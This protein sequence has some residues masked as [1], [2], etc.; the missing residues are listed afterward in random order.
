MKHSLRLIASSALGVA[1]A[2][3]FPQAASA[4]GYLKIGDI[5]GEST[6]EGHKDEIEIESWS[7]GETSTTRLPGEAAPASGLATGK[8]QHKPL[9]ITKAVDKASPKL[10]EASVGG[11]MIPSMTLTLPKGEGKEQ[12]YLTYKLKNVM[13]TSYQTSSAAG[14]ED[15]PMETFSLNYEEIKTVRPDPDKPIRTTVERQ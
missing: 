6:D 13:I 5:K 3:A 10:Q 15:V 7:W 1:L 14:G 8:R 11:R 9:T 4:A 2:L 12:T